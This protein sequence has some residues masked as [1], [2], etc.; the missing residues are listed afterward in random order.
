MVEGSIQELAKPIKSS[1]DCK[2]Y[3][4]IKLPN[5]LTAL[6]VSDTSYDLEKLDQE[7]AELVENVFNDEEKDGEEE[8][9]EEEDNDEEE[10]DENGE[11]ED[12]EGEED[13]EDEEEDSEEEDDDDDEEGG[14][15]EISA[16]KKLQK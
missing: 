2:D 7:E 3:K 14:S 1:K 10:E 11:G 9:E 15:G 12:E 5:G 4:V 6:L 13:V 8:E 16:T